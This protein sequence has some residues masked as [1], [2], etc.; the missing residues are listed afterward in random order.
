MKHNKVIA[1]LA[2]A[3]SLFAVGSAHAFA[4]AVAA[5][6]AAVVGAGVGN[7]HNQADQARADQARAEQAR[8]AAMANSTVVLGGPS[9]VVHEGMPAPGAGYQWQQGHFE[10]QNGVSTWVPGRW[11]ASEVVIHEGN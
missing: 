6:I 3:G 5:G 4:P 1:T 9:V 8:A 10:V 2:I 11:V 7:A